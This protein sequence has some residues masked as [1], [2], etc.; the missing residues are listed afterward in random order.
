[1]NKVM[2]T[3]LTTLL[4]VPTIASAQKT[5]SAPTKPV[6]CAQ[7]LKAR[8][9]LNKAPEAH[10]TCLKG[11]KPVVAKDIIVNR[12]FKDAADFAKKIEDIGKKIY[13]LNKANVTF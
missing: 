7:V 10:L 13:D 1:M 5:T 11:V 12:P 2:L 8:V 4:L 6:S 9:N 3:A